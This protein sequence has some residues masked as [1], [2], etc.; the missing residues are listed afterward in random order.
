MLA[1]GKVCE[2]TLKYVVE[3]S[4][5][6]STTGV[7]FAAPQGCMLLGI[8]FASFGKG[9]LDLVVPLKKTP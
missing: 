7:N 6:S 5:S 4:E 2:V 9:C 3:G 8:H 1:V